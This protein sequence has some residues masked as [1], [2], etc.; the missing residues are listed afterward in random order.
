MFLQEDEWDGNNMEI[1]VTNRVSD[2]HE[3]ISSHLERLINTEI[4]YLEEQ[5]GYNRYSTYD[6]FNKSITVCQDEC[7]TK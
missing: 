7:K 6:Y 5:P 1:F 4:W 2:N 3:N